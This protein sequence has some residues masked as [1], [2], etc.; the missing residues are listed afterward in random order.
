MSEMIPKFI[1]INCEGIPLRGLKS[2]L[3]PERFLKH[4]YYIMTRK[5]LN[6]HVD[7]DFS[8]FIF[9]LASLVNLENFLVDEGV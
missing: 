6:L 1:M 2:R 7:N 8:K 4:E 9:D 3:G 5:P